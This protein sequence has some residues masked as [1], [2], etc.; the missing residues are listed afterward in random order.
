[1]EVNGTK[2]RRL[3]PS[4]PPLP[5]LAE[6]RSMRR[7]DRRSRPDEVA[8]RHAFG[9]T[10]AALRQGAA[11]GLDAVQLTRLAHETAWREVTAG[12]G[13]A[14][15]AARADAAMAVAS[16]A[17]LRPADIVKLAEV[18]GGSTRMLVEMARLG[19]IED[20]RHPRLAVDATRS[21]GTLDPAYADGSPHQAYH[22]GFF[23][24]AGYVSAGHPVHTAK[25]MAA[26]FMHE[27]LLDEGVRR[28]VAAGATAGASREDWLASAFGLLAGQRLKVLGDAGKGRQM[29]TVLAGAM[30]RVP[31]LLPRRLPEADHEEA[32]AQVRALRQQRD[33]WLPLLDH[34]ALRGLIGPE[35][36]AMAQVVRLLGLSPKRP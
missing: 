28:H 10:E 18:D 25:A 30:S 15:P 27:T 24:A 19:K 14:S 21:A 26:A 16:M 33:Q 35:S 31:S 5:P 7:R 22:M 36:A 32:L 3:P 2:Q 9:V 1:M 29:A 23:V 13:H 12:A 20:P 4:P 6:E 8:L 17:I 11:E 34:P